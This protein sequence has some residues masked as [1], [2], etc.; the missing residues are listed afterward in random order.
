M[1]SL[2]LSHL[3]VA[4]TLW[5]KQRRYYG[6]S[7]QVIWSWEM[8]WLLC[9]RITVFHSRSVGGV[10]WEVRQ[11]LPS[12]FAWPLVR[13]QSQEAG[14]GKVETAGRCWCSGTWTPHPLTLS[15]WPSPWVDWLH[16]RNCSLTL[17]GLPLTHLPITTGCCASR[18]ELLD[19]WDSNLSNTSHAGTMQLQGCGAF[20]DLAHGI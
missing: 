14:M 20:W 13:K 11:I 3:I 4:T 8:Q 9:G 16:V 6:T 12:C 1:L 2:S 10:S 17:S 7:F 18:L 19:T 5:H 15:H